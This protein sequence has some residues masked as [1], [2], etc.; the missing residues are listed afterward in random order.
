MTRAAATY[1]PP[2]ASLPSPQAQAKAQAKEAKEAAAAAALHREREQEAAAAL[3]AE[4]AARMLA[5]EPARWAG[6]EAAA[7]AEE[8]GLEAAARR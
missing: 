8:L 6:R 4:V 5:T 3:A 7:L 2:P 1:P